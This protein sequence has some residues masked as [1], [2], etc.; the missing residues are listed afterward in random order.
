MIRI[1]ITAIDRMCLRG[2]LVAVAALIVGAAEGWRQPF[3]FEAGDFRCKA[4]RKSSPRLGDE[5][6]PGCGGHRLTAFYE[7]FHRIIV[8]NLGDWKLS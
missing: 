1:Q 4:R 5:L 7:R 6:G 2:F 8:R 3:A